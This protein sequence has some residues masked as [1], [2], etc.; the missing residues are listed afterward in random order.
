MS[1]PRS[2]LVP[3][4]HLS[5]DEAEAIARRVLGFA[6]ADE[7]RVTINSG[8]RG[9]TRFAVN[10]ISTAG[11]SYDVTVAVRS[12]FGRRSGTVTTNR[13]DDEGL[14]RAVQTSEQLARLAPEDPEALPELGPQ[15]YASTSAWSEST[16][17][18]EPGSRAAAV[19]AIA[20][21]ARTAGLASTGYL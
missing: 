2:L 18:L 7:T 16:A 14:R 21:P 15:Q 13:L 3:A 12:V 6:T 1:A 5:R 11:D 17:A 19:R 10:Q 9:N 20:T 4:R 8:A